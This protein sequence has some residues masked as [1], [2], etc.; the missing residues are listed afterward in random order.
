MDGWKFPSLSNNIDVRSVAICQSC[1]LHALSIK[2]SEDEKEETYNSSKHSQ[3]TMNCLID[4]LIQFHPFPI[5][6]G[7]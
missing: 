2:M 6:V 7:L 4:L 1:P 3:Q 5:S